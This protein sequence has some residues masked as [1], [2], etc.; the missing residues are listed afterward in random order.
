MAPPPGQIPGA[1]VGAAGVWQGLQGLGLE[2]R[3]QGPAAATSLRLAVPG[4]GQ[5]VVCGER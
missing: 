5:E 2:Q 3:D 1:G 4:K